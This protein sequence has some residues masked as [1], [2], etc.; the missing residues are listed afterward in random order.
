MLS[1]VNLVPKFYPHCFGCNFLVRAP[2]C[3]LFSS[4]DSSLR[5]IL[6][7]LKDKVYLGTL[8]FVGFNYLKTLFRPSKMPRKLMTFKNHKFLHKIDCFTTITTP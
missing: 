3:E 6:F 7:E 1:E 4:L 8:Y 2:F 5:F